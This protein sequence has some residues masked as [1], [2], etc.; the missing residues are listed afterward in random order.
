MVQHVCDWVYPSLISQS[1]QIDELLVLG[2][3]L[4]QK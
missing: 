4:S 3:T 1:S 2:D